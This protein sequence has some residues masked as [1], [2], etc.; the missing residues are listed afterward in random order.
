[1]YQSANLRCPPDYFDACLNA[2]QELFSQARSA[3][4]VPSIGFRNVLFGLRSY[5]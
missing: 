5:D 3:T 4:F 1:M 2:T